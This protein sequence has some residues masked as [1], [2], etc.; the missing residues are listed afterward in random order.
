MAKKSDRAGEEGRRTGCRGLRRVGHVGDGFR[1]G[2]LRS[3]RRTGRTTSRPP[4][5]RRLARRVRRKGLRPHG[6]PPTSDERGGRASRRRAA[7]RGPRAAGQGDPSPAAARRRRPPPLVA[8]FAIDTSQS[9]TTIGPSIV[10]R[11]KLKCDENLIVSG[12]LEADVKSTKDLRIENQGIMNANIDVHA[13]SISGIVVGDIR[14]S[15]LGGARVGSPGH[16]QHRDA[17]ADH[18]R[19]CEVPRH[20]RDGGPP[21]A[22]ARE[23]VGSAGRGGAGAGGAA[24]SIRSA[25][26]GAGGG[27]RG[28]VD[29]RHAGPSAEPRGDGGAVDRRTAWSRWR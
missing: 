20:H 9:Y 1:R 2:V 13:V 6:Q 8:G 23:A 11:G 25:A 27:G 4:R 10:I 17:A 14:A 5:L 19:R 21:V 16:R 26:S 22:R 29:Q 7:G 28:G 3:Q 15:E 24:P 12:R 18:P